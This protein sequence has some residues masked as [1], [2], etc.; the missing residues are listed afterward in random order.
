MQFQVTGLSSAKR[1][2][3]DSSASTSG[4]DNT[5]VLALQGYIPYGNATL[6]TEAQMQEFRSPRPT[7]ADLYRMYQ[8]EGPAI[9]FDYQNDYAYTMRVGKIEKNSTKYASASSAKVAR[10]AFIAVL[11][12]LLSLS[13]ADW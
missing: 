10:P 2:L 13:F 9:P 5:G 1:R 3:S 7:K 6:A 4:A 11:L 12:G 8:N